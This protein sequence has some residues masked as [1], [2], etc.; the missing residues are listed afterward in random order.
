MK[1]S[2]S[3]E[4]GLV[5]TLTA[6]GIPPASVTR[7]AR[8]R[9][10]SRQIVLPMGMTTLLLAAVAYDWLWFLNLAP[11]VAVP[12]PR[13]PVPNAFDFFCAAGQQATHDTEIGYAISNKKPDPGQN[14][15]QP[16]G[17]PIS[18]SQD[19]MQPPALMGGPPTAVQK[20][21]DPNRYYSLPEKEALVNENTGALKLLRQGLPYP[22][23]NPPARSYNQEFPYYEQFRSLARLL[24]LEGQVRAAHGDWAGAVNSSLDAMQMG[25][26]MPH[27]STMLGKLVGLGC[28]KIGRKPLWTAVEHLNAAQTQAAEKRIEHI[29]TLYVPLADT[30]QEEKWFGQAA[31]QA[32]F[33]Q[34]H[35][36]QTLTQVPG[37]FPMLNPGY[38]LPMLRYSKRQILDNYTRYMDQ[39]IINMRLPYTDH[40]APVPMPEDPV[41]QIRLPIYTYYQWM[42]LADG[43]V[44]DALLQVMLALR[45]YH[46]DHNQYP[47]ALAQLVPKYISKIPDDPFAMQDS[48]G[49]LIGR[50]LMLTGLS[51]EDTVIMPAPLRYRRT[52]HKYVLYSVGPDG[53]DNGGKPMAKLDQPQNSS[54][55][56]RMQEDGLGD[57]VAGTNQD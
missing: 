31:M 5:R 41:N 46:L 33:L 55:R 24:T 57:I 25:A 30:L 7:F 10:A 37:G 48:H 49:R 50:M 51:R 34:M 43:Q 1:A 54:K 3:P 28:E 45:A 14:I 38:V 23:Q 36:W 13:M 4:E 47:Q 12:M 32:A 44:Q 40:S 15:V 27:G 18:P 29:R 52:A 2:L 42:D 6:V 21:H 22:Y 16:T 11:N 20:P 26:Q 56:Y 53:V 35:W 8:L 19:G 9:L 39:S 17:S